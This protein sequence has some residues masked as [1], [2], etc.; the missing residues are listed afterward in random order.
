M[1]QSDS[2]PSKGVRGAAFLNFHSVKNRVART[3][4]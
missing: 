3:G 2:S 1:S 4:F